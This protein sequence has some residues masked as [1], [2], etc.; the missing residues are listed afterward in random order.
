MISVY[1]RRLDAVTQTSVV[2]LF[3]AFPISLSLANLLM[4]WVF[5]LWLLSGR[6]GQA[7]QLLKSNPAACAALALFGVVLLGVLYSPAPWPDIQN[8]LE[9]YVKLIMVAVLLFVLAPVPALQQRALLAFALAMGFTAAS[10]WLNIWWQLPWSETQDQGWGVNHHVFGDYITQNVMMSLFVLLALERVWNGSVVWRRGLWALT[11]LLAA[12]SITH[13]SIGRTGFVLL[14]VVLGV[15]LLAQLRGRTLLLA[16][17]A[18]ALAVA[19]V[20][21]SSAPMQQRFAQAWA[22]AR[23]FE[24][25]N[26]SSIGHRIYNIETTTR[27]VLQ[28]P[29]L[30]WGTGAYHTEICHV[31]ED[32]AQ[33]PTFSWHPHNQYLFFAAG[34]G[35]LGLGI[36]L[37]LLGGMAWQAQ[38]STHAQARVLLLGLTALL[39][40]NSLFNSPLWSARESHFFIFMAGLL[41]SMAWATRKQCLVGE[42]E[43]PIKTET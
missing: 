8:H 34:H 23:Q 29:L 28:K 12:L 2:A 22:E 9:K 19:A 4:V 16:L 15:F 37:A 20:F 27:L 21:A 17:T 3:F 33:C 30:G 14:L 18:A 26:Q 32:P 5:L 1:H 6:F 31:L 42:P 41:L 35:V 24:A 11:G 13:L 36:F 39:A 43:P 40:V 10:S 38:R 7:G 25:D